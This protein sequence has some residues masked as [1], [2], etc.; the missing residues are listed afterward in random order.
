MTLETGI[1]AACDFR[2]PRDLMQPDDGRLRGRLTAMAL[3]PLRFAVLTLIALSS[4]FVGGGAAFASAAGAI[5]ALVPVTSPAPFVYDIS[6]YRYDD[7]R[8]LL[9]HERNPSRR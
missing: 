9:D 4:V 6:E 3:M 1:R 2:D 7:G 5:A 8:H